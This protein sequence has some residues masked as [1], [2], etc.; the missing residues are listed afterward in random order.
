M[1]DMVVRKPAR[2]TNWE[3]SRCIVMHSARN[4]RYFYTTLVLGTSHPHDLAVFLPQTVGREVKEPSELSLLLFLLLLFPRHFS[5]SSILLSI[6][7]GGQSPRGGGVF[8]FLC[9]S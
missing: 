1:K 8:P 2:K 6:F 7:L 9:L 5:D 3:F 4:I